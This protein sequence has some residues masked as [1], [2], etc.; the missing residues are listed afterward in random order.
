ME[1]LLNTAPAVPRRKGW[2]MARQRD[3]S[4][5]V[6]AGPPAGHAPSRPVIAARLARAGFRRSCRRDAVIDAFLA[7]DRHVSVEELTAR[8]RAAGIGSTTVY[9]T[10]K[11]LA[12]QGFASARHFGDGQTRYE[13]ARPGGHHDHLVCRVCGTVQEFSDAELEEAQRAVARRHGFV[14]QG[15]TF[16][17]HG[18]CRR[19]RAARAREAS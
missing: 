17:L 5:P 9:R 7:S 1:V 15:H 8:V 4:P 10:M 2:M 18:R 12:E 3:E 19:C 14:L 11:L 6:V 16:E 13:P